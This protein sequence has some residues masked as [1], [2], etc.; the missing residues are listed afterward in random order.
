MWVE[1][2]HVTSCNRVTHECLMHAH[3]ERS[4]G[5]AHLHECVIL[6]QHVTCCIQMN[7][8]YNTVELCI[9][10]HVNIVYSCSY[11][12]L[13]H[14]GIHTKIK[15][16]FCDS[17]RNNVLLQLKLVFMTFESQNDCM[18]CTPTLTWPIIIRPP[19]QNG[20]DL[21]LK[22]LPWHTANLSSMYDVIL[23]Y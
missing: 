23:M 12:A 4:G 10:L 9:Y 19:L 8:Q 11:S 18:C 1:I 20:I 5:C 13:L 16:L 17:S 14:E 22:N 21:A 15:L 2:Q 6:L 7:I 3:P